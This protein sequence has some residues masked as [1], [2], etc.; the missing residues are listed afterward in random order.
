MA[1]SNETSNEELNES[2]DKNITMMQISTNIP[3][4]M[5]FPC[6]SNTTI[7]SGELDH[8]LDTRKVTGAHCSKVTA[9]QS[10]PVCTPLGQQWELSRV[11][12]TGFNA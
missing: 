6:D 9:R 4:H 11:G 3:K 12:C 7:D 5:G 1:K 2:Y 10:W 8:S